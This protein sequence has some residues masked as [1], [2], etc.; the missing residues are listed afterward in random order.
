[1][2]MPYRMAKHATLTIAIRELY[3]NQSLPVTP[4]YNAPVRFRVVRASAGKS[5]LASKQHDTASQATLIS[6]GLM[7]E[8]GL[9]VDSGRKVKI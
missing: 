6:K 8:L 1:M 9:V 7:S 2:R 4:H 5:T 3:E